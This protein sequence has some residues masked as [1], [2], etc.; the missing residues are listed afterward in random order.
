MFSLD[1]N[2]IA[3]LP[4]SDCLTRLDFRIGRL[5]LVYEE[6]DSETRHTVIYLVLGRAMAR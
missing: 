5:S 1:S 6:C 3:F 4:A 2:S